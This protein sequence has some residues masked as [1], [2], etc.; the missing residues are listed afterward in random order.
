[1][2]PRIWLWKKR[3][4]SCFKNLL[5]KIYLIE[6]HAKVFAAIIRTNNNMLPFV[7]FSVPLSMRVSSCLWGSNAFFVLERFIKAPTLVYYVPFPSHWWN[8]DEILLFFFGTRSHTNGRIV[9]TTNSSL[10]KRPERV[11]GRSQGKRHVLEGNKVIHVH[12]AEL[13]YQ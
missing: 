5:W 2:I 1:M 7:G 11:R 6:E 12:T 4:P 9:H 8:R 3:T 13:V 10:R